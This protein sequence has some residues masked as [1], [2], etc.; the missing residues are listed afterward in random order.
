MDDY[1]F[2]IAE[3]AAEQDSEGNWQAAASSR[4]K[5]F[6]KVGSPTRSEFFGALQAG[7]ETAIV[8]EVSAW[9]YAGEAIIEYQGDRYAVR[10]SYRK[11]V[12]IIELSCE[13]SVS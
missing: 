12:D 8:A 1:V 11:S 7:Y 6:A 3:N 4:R 9:D 10:K 2:L 5:V 13:R